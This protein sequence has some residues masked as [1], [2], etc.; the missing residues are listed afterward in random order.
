MKPHLKSWLS[1][2][3]NFLVGVLRLMRYLRAFTRLQVQIATD[4]M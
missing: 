4:A 1:N 2:L 3:T